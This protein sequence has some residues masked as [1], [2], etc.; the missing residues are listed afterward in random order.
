MKAV[1]EWEKNRDKEKGE[2]RNVYRK[3]TFATRHIKTNNCKHINKKLP[4][5]K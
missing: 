2:L 3:T 4:S 5:R 1:G